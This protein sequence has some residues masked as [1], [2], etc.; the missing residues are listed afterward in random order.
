MSSLYTLNQSINQ[1][2]KTIKMQFTTIITVIVSVMA[3]VAIA[4]PVPKPA[5]EADAVAAA[6]RGEASA[7][8][9]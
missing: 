1:A 8:V 5:P 2:N 4:N 3:S 6:P 9:S 7:T